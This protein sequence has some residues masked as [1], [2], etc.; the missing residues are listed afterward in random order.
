MA[1]TVAELRSE[2][3]AQLAASGD[4]ATWTD[5]LLDGALRRGLRAIDAYGPVYEATHTVTVAGAE[6]DLRALPGL[7]AVTG[8]AWPWREGALFE[9]AAVR[10][11]A[12]GEG[13]QVRLRTGTPAVGDALR[14]RYRKAHALQGLDGAAATTLP[15]ALRPTLALGGACYAAQLRE[16]QAIENPALPPDTVH[17]PAWLGGGD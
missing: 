15:D 14:V 11:R 4:S 12:L 8:L 6:Q 9:E 7:C 5:A 16:R 13:G 10:W 1:Y 17:A 2:V 3:L